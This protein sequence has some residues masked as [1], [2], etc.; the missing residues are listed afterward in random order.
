MSLPVGRDRTF[1]KVRRVYGEHRLGLLLRHFEVVEAEFWGK[2]DCDRWQC[3]S[4]AAALGI[5]P[6]RGIGKQPESG[7][8]HNLGLFTLRRPDG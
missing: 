1:Q 2:N 8:Y 6:R 5:E 4:R 7:A 3:V